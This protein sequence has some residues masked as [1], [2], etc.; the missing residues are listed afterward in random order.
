MIKREVWGSLR[1]AAVAG[2]QKRG[3]QALT[4]GSSI[5]M[6]SLGSCRSD[7][8]VGPANPA[9]ADGPWRNLRCLAGGKAMVR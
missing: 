5:P 3:K 2:G 1:E 6:D 4:V 7:R 9:V 8:R